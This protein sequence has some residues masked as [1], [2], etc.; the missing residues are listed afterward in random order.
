MSS[1][2]IGLTSM[3][4]SRRARLSHVM[5]MASSPDRIARGRIVEISLFADPERLGQLD[6]T[7]LKQ[8][9]TATV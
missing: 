3:I 9:K 1:L 7:I 2:S 6:L 4:G 8:L 5:T